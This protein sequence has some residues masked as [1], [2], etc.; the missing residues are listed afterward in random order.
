MQTVCEDGCGRI[1]AEHLTPLIIQPASPDLLH[2]LDA[3]PLV[4]IDPALRDW[5]ARTMRVHHDFWTRRLA[6]EQAIGRT[7][8]DGDANFFQPGLF[9]RR[10]DRAHLADAHDQAQLRE[11]AVRRSVLAETAANATIRSGRPLLILLP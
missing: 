3:T 6:R 8:I 1:V 9:D 2:R 11:E 10:A 7:L 5:Q 4:D